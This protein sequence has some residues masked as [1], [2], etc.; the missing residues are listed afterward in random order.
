MNVQ[1]DMPSVV[2]AAG[3]SMGA[4]VWALTVELEATRE[5][6]RL[7]QARVEELEKDKP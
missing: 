3:A 4:H 1:V 7:T 5:A 2:Q 6:L